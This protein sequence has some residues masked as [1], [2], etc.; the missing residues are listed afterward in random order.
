MA[1]GFPRQPLDIVAAHRAFFNP[2]G[3]HHAQPGAIQAIG[4]TKDLKQVVALAEP[5]TKNG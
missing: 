5:E 3:H 4:P 2:L 1:V